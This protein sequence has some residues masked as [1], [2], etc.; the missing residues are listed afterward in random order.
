MSVIYVRDRNEVLELSFQDVTKYHGSLALMA[1]AVGFRTLQAAFAEL[2]GEEAPDRKELSI[3]SGHAGPGFR[4]VF[5]YV[6]R[7][8]TRGA[9]R[10]DVDYPVAQYDPHRPQSYAFV[11][12]AADGRAVEVSLS[13]S[14]L[15]AEFYDYLKKGREQAMTEQDVEAFDKLKLALSRRALALPQDELLAIKRIA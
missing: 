1:V 2:F 9:Y 13:A 3:L 5:E 7:A 12:T 15:P 4:D 6:T 8:V 14:F 11:I 10:V